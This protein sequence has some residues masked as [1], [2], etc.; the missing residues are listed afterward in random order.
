MR[1]QG[2]V[3]VMVVTGHVH[4]LFFVWGLTCSSYKGPLVYITA[5][6]VLEIVQYSFCKSPLKLVVV[7]SICI[8]L[9]CHFVFC[10]C[11]PALWAL[12]C[13]VICKDQI[14]YFVA[15]QV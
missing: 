10:F 6:R 8:L 4:R 11:G 13:V 7:M 9:I 14:W 5:I 2:L 1:D 3:R 15:H 12:Y